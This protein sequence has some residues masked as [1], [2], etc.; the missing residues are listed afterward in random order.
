MYARNEKKLGL[1]DK[2]I[3]IDDFSPSLEQAAKVEGSET[4][5]GDSSG[6]PAL[7]SVKKPIPAGAA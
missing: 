7:A 2:S 3:D 5:A 6:M 1:L 4:N